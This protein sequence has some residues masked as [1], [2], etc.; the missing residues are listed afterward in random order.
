MRSL[1]RTVPTAAVG[2]LG[3]GLVACGGKV[4]QEVFD[5]EMAEVRQRLAGHDTA[6]ARG[7]STMSRHAAR[8]DSLDR[9]IERLRR[10][11]E[12]LREE[13]GARIDRLESGLTFAMPVH[14]AFDSSSVD[15]SER[16]KLDRFAAVVGEHYRDATVT[17]EGFADPAGPETYN[18]RL[19]RRRAEA[20]ARYLRQEA[21]MS[22]DRLRAVG[23]GESRLVRPDA[24]GPG[25]EGRANRR[26]TFVVE[27]APSGS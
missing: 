25:A 24:A 19:S 3:A 15:P 5:E 13:Y 2:L 17:V 16:E 10:D 9:R 18:R 7:D 14:F 21:E 22:G 27:F 1:L 11:L 6:L 23:Y 20:V 12:S 4:D 8:L 26:V